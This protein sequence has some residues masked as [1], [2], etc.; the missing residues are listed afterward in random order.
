MRALLGL[1]SRWWRV[2]WRVAGSGLLLLLVGLLLL[3]VFS[4][5]AASRA[6]HHGGAAASS[7]LPVAT[8]P[9]LTYV[10][11]GASDAFGVGTADPVHES[12]PVDLAQRLGPHV[13]LLD[14]GLPGVTAA[15][16]AQSELPIAL[17][18]NP[19]IVTIWLGVNDLETGVPLASYSASLDGMIAAL[20][21]RTH[22]AIYVANLPDLTLLPYFSGWDPGKLRSE[23]NAWNATI[24]Q[25]CARDG[26][27]LVDLASFSN[28][29]ANAPEDIADDGLHP[30]TAGA[31]AL[32]GAFASIIRTTQGDQH[33]EYPRG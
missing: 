6:V 7:A 2:T 30:S 11:I 17:A 22:A 25:V 15:Q 26:A 12:W 29:L 23:V 14:L 19:R 31:A 9:T 27:T 18:S 33:L 20:R 21:S 13:Q 4:D 16:A 1:R 28:A 32:A 24:A 5:A 3:R 10:A 8:V